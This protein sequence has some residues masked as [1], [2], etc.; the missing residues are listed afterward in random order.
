MNLTEIFKG[1]DSEP[2]T[3]PR[4]ATDL[5]KE[6]HQKVK[7]LFQEF[8]GLEEDAEQ[9]K[10]RL[11]EQIRRELTVHAKV[12][13]EIFYPAV[14]KLPEDEATDLVLEAAEE[15]AIV[16]TLLGQLESLDAGDDVF[17]AKMKVMMEAVEHHA[18][19]EESDMFPEARKGLDEG[20]L[21]A[22]GA[23]IEAR[24]SELVA[25]EERAGRKS[26]RSANFAPKQ[27]KPAR[28]VVKG[29]ASRKSSGSPAKRRAR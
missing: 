13:E 3:A 26:P 8:R 4:K 18:D 12:E 28:S 21:V 5:L 14:R 19:E 9:E 29:G 24:K 10:G 23:R 16:K 7:G 20:A 6:D 11:F 2:G 15:H 1:K 22:L 17:D 25:I 27:R